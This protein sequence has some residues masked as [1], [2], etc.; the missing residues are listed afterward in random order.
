[1][2]TSALFPFFPEFTNSQ[3]SNVFLFLFLSMKIVLTISSSST[4][5]QESMYHKSKI[6]QR[7]LILL[8]WVGDKQ[9]SG[10]TFCP[11]NSNY[12]DRQLNT[13]CEEGNYQ[14]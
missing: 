13:P 6:S 7:E 10:R 3:S 12:G 1:M 4:K 5:K 9:W 14:Q 11:L 8:S 2:T